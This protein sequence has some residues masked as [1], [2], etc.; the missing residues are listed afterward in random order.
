MRIQEIHWAELIKLRRD[1]NHTSIAFGLF[2]LW[3]KKIGE[4]EVADVIGSELAL[5]TFRRTSQLGTHDSS[6]VEQNIDLR[7]ECCD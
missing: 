3:Y 2:E 6:V 1:I 4:K 7:N 5:Y